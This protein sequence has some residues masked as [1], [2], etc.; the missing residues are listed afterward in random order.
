MHIATAIPNLSI[1]RIKEIEREFELFIND[2]NPSVTDKTTRY[3]SKKDEGLGMIK[4]DHFWKAIKMSWLRRLYFSKSTW[5]E[6]HKAETKPNTFNPISSNWSEIETAKSRMNNPIW[7][8]IYDAL[9]T[10]RK[11]LL[12]ANPLE[13]LTLLVNGE[14][15]I[16]KNNTSIQQPWCVN[17]TINDILNVD[18]NLKKIE[19]Y[20][21]GK[22]P[23]FL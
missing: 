6:L 4:I 20:P 11:N 18:G 19:E 16:T 3:M 21:P 7:K 1:G 14:P 9:L 15:Y 13:L 22:K 23:V 10:C 8:E 12:K 2:N 5:A 17:L